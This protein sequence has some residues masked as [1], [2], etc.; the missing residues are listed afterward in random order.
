MSVF[1]DGTTSVTLRGV[2]SDDFQTLEQSTRRTAGGGTRTIRTG[3]RYVTQEEYR[4]TGAEYKELVDLLTNGATQY[5]F[6]PSVIPD[7]MSESDFPLLCN[8]GSPQKERQAGGGNKKY[9]FNIKIESVN[10]L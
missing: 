4:T 6:T 2:L 5:F 1:S 7:H 3:S 9:F 8:I 10:Y